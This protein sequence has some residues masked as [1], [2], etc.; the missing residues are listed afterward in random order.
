MTEPLY[1]YF[2]DYDPAIGRYVESDPSGLDG[3]INTYAYVVNR[4]T[5]LHDPVGKKTRC[6]SPLVWDAMTG[7]CNPP[8]PPTPEEECLRKCSLATFL[9]CRPVAFGAG[10]ALGTLVGSTTCLVAPEACMIGV[11]GGGIAGGVAVSGLCKVV[12]D[13][14]CARRCKNPCETGK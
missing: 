14:E 5:M 2:R 9:L 4:P 12:G 3:G 1:N 11:R 6:P 13:E 8:R 10:Q 7:R